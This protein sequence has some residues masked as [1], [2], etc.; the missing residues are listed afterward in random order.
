MRYSSV[1]L[2][3]F[4]YSESG[5]GERLI[6]PPLGLGYLSEYLENKGI[7]I[8]VL[9]MG[10]GKKMD[11]CEDTMSQ[12]IERF[13]PALIGVSLNSIC[14][15]RSIEI[16][17]NIRKKYPEISISVG[18]P[19][20]SSKGVELLKKYNFLDYII[21]REGEK[22]MA[23]LC[24]GEELSKIPGLSWKQ[25]E[26]FYSNPDMPSEDLSE[27]PF[28]KYKKFQLDLYASP[29]SIGILTSR[30]CPYQ[31]IFC[32]Q[33]ALLGK[34]WRGRTP[35]SII[36][37]ISY[38]KSQGKRVIYILDDNSALN[39]QRI[40]DLSRLVIEKGLNDMKYII[41]GGVRIDQANKETLTA[42]KQMGVKTIPFGVES[43]S[44][45]ILQFM[46]KGITAEMADKAIALAVSM[47]FEVKLFFIIGFPTETMEDVQKSF[48]LALK[49]PIASVRFFNLFPYPDTALM[50]WLKNNKTHFFYQ[51]DE[52]MNSF[53]RF[54]RIP[55]FEN[56]SGMNYQEKVKALN[57]ADEV[58][59]TV[60]NKYREYKQTKK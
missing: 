30:G 34:K 9:D 19:D 56:S 59:K 57:L 21:A 18:G 8:E 50:E 35:E 44:D 13:K 60:E 42:L 31:C 48:N 17:S 40:L 38:W 58:I 7:Q 16:L 26:T 25:G 33:S 14:F 5:Y 49:H 54:Q 1:F 43:G 29:D 46:K 22:A 23:K 36:E 47:G 6:Y 52:Y 53:K 39:K 32:Q 20:A 24:L 55:L 45:K 15:R 3:N 4:Y 27:F 41:V 37:E 11:Q 28:P 51:R 2:V 10:T 12:Y